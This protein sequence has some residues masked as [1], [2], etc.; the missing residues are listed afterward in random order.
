M[1]ADASPVKGSL[2]VMTVPLP[3]SDEAVI[4]P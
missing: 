1:A 4:S 3:G 2:T